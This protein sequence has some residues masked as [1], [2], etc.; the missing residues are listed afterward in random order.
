MP[1]YLL[2]SKSTLNDTN[3]CC[4]NS[5]DGNTAI[6]FNNLATKLLDMS[7]AIE[8]RMNELKNK[9]CVSQKQGIFMA[10]IETPSMSLGIK[11]EYIEYIKRYGPPYN[12]I[13]DECKL[14][15]IRIELN[16]PIIKLI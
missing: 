2:S 3:C 10:S 5:I 9:V 8:L 13:F 15:D 7:N 14:N 6:F 4:D 16:I 1:S 11:Y 12:G